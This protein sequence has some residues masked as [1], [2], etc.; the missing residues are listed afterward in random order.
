MLFSKPNNGH[1]SRA[2]ITVTNIPLKYLILFQAFASPFVDAQQHIP[3]NNNI[4]N[5]NESLST[6]L[7][8]SQ[9]SKNNPDDMKTPSTRNLEKIH[10]SFADC[11]VG[12]GNMEA[13]WRETELDIVTGQPTKMWKN[14]EIIKIIKG[15]YFL[16]WFHSPLYCQDLMASF[17][18][19]SAANSNSA[20]YSVDGWTRSDSFENNK[21]LNKSGPE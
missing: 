2:K 20:T 13:Q 8:K 4:S 16:E 11:Q 1:N 7:R 10:D 5:N 9:N 17:T 19:Y 12:D 6:Y 3:N 21:I 14:V 18:I 15:K